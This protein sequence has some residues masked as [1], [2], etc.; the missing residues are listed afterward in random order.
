MASNNTPR[1]PWL[2]GLLTLAT[3]GLGHHYSGNI[4]RGLF[5]FAGGQIVFLF[6]CLCLL[7]YAPLGQSIAIAAILSFLLFCIMDAVKRT[8]P[9][10]RRYTLKKENRWYYYLLYFFIGTFA[11]QP[12]FQ[13]SLKKHVAQAYRIPSGSMRHTLQIGDHIVTNKLRFK[14]SHPKRG[15]IVVFPSPQDPKKYFLQRVVGLGGETLEIRDKHVFIN[16]QPL[17]EPY[18]VHLDKHVFSSAQQPRDNLD[19][20]TIPA[21]ALF[22]M[23]DNRDNS[24]DSRFWGVVQR[25]A[26]EG[27]ATSIYWSWDEA[28]LRVRWSRIGKTID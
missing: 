22:V 23:G 15:D 9:F 16:A 12:L 27:E 26:V 25:A 13:W 3:I 4:K 2:A 19:P 14:Y 11:I 18:A 10:K 8:G 17:D 5:L 1:K 28:A 20:L 24:Y 7:F 21:D 6:A